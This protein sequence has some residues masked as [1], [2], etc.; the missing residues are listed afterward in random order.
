MKVAPVWRRHFVILTSTHHSSALF[1]SLLIQNNT[2][3]LHFFYT[4]G[5]D[6]KHVAKVS[7]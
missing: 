4:E 2:S 1:T 6:S 7:W 5:Q 3:G